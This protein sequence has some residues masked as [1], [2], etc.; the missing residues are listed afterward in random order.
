MNKTYL[1]LAIVALTCFWVF[2]SMPKPESILQNMTVSD[3]SI[4]FDGVTYALLM[5]GSSG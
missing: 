5:L 3:G 4:Q 1:L 2:N